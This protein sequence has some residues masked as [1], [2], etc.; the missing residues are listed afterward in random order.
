MKSEKDRLTLTKRSSGQRGR[1]GQ[2]LHTH[3]ARD[4]LRQEPSSQS[5]HPPARHI[6]AQDEH[7]FPQSGSHRRR[8]AHAFLCAH[9]LRRLGFELVPSFLRLRLSS[10]ETLVASMSSSAAICAI[11]L[12][13]I[14]RFSMATRISNVM[15]E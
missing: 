3:G 6:L 8:T 5:G 2:P 4:V 11:D 15:C 13:S 7:F 10:R 1:S 9:R 12:P 14:T